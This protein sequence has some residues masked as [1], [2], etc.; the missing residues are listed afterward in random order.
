MAACRMTDTFH[1][2]IPVLLNEAVDK[3]RYSASVIMLMRPGRGGHSSLA[4][5]NKLDLIW[6]LDCI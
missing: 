1:Q 5:L 4:I 3:L 2:H 6:P